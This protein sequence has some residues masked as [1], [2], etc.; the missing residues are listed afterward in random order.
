MTNNNSMKAARH[1]SLALLLLGPVAAFAEES[2]VSQT[3]WQDYCASSGGTVVTLVPQFET[4]SGMTRGVPKQ[5]CQ[6]STDGNIEFLGLDTLASNAPS[7]ASTFAK[8]LVIDTTKP[9]PTK[10]Y[11]NPSLNVCSRLKGTSISFN[12]N[13]GFADASGQT[14]ICVFGDGSAISAWTLI[15]LADGALPDLKALIKAEPMAIIIP[16]VQIGT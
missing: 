2:A 5:F 3:P 11:S 10:P 8:S 1:L 4:Q 12:V 16:D 13:G 9:L 7:L 6:Y 15:Y 14:D